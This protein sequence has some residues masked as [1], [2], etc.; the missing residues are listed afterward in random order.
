MATDLILSKQTMSSLEI[1]EHKLKCMFGNDFGEE[2][3]QSLKTKKRR[4]YKTYIAIDSSTGYVKIGKSINPESRIRALATANVHIK[5]YAIMNDDCEKELQKKL[6]NY[7][8]S[9]EWFKISHEI[10]NGIT[11]K[12]KFNIISHE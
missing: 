12:Y 5:L 10:L 2:L 9:G 6:I 4:D 3:I 1:A 7:K 8:I 11:E